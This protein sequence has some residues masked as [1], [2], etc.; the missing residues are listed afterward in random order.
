MTMVLDFA[1]DH[2]TTGT[3]MVAIALADRVNGDTS[4][5][6]PSIADIS[7]RTGIKERQV[8][9]HLRQLEDEGVI[10]RLGQRKKPDGTLGSNTYRWCLWITLGN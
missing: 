2:W 1:P 9:R 6:F 7:R 10:A 3:R 8:Q 4:E 5:C